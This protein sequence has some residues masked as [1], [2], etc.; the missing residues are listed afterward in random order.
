MPKYCP[1][2]NMRK[3]KRVSVCPVL[4]LTADPGKIKIS[5]E[6]KNWK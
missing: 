5:V 6:K 3:I 1:H 2:Y 4:F